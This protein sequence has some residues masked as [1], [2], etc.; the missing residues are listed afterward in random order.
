M[1]GGVLF[2]GVVC[3]WVVFFGGGGGGSW[4]CD[5][6]VGFFLGGGRV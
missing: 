1:D 5:G 2:Q 3:R 4:R 6:F